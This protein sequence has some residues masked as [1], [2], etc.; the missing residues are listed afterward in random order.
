MPQSEKAEAYAQVEG[1]PGGGAPVV[2]KVGF[3]DVVAVEVVVL[4][5]ILLEVLDASRGVRP[6]T[7]GADQEIGKRVSQAQR[8]VD[9]AE[10][11]D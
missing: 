1:Q 9:I 4:R 7:A 10:T 11:Q 3:D 8:T 2:L 5:A 6:E